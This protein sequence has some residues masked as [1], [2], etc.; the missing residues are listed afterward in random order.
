[1]K[2][3]E[4]YDPKK[5]KAEPAPV[6]KPKPKPKRSRFKWTAVGEID[7][8]ADDNAGW[9]IEGL[10]P[11]QGV[12]VLYGRWKSYKSF[13][14]IDLAWHVALGKMWA[15][16]RI[17]RR[18]AVIYI[19]CEGQSGMRKRIMAYKIAHTEDELPPLWLVEG[20]PDLGRAPISDDILDL[21]SGKTSNIQG[22]EIALVIIDTLARTLN[23]RDENGE[24]MRNF[25]DNAEELAERLNCLVLAVHHEGAIADTGRPR[26]GT[27]LPAG[28][29]ATWHVKRKSNGSGLACALVVEEAKDSVSDFGFDVELEHIQF[30]DEHDERRES[31]LKVKSI[32]ATDTAIADS[33][34]KRKVTPKLMAF[35]TA[36]NIALDR[37]GIFVRLPDNGPTV[38]A[39]ALEYFRPVY[40]GRR[41]DLEAESKRKAWRDQLAAA[42]E[43][44][45]I[46]ARSINGIDMTYLPTKSAGTRNGTEHSG[47][48]EP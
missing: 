25:L 14:A 42:V 33:K 31:T 7:F 8:T 29:V 36:F 45:F 37:H 16:R 11:D 32:T 22:E 4:P 1:M 30:G 34:P 46:V 9:L 44:E 19:A 47:T 38:K 6:D 3:G 5:R 13:V 48:A 27:V 41:G 18:G 43:G 28:V 21:V 40:Y 39:V 35:M 23:G 24:G 10:L 2:R 17:R 12:A 20:R 15:G 26:G